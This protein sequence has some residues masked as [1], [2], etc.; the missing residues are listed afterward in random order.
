[1]KEQETKDNIHGKDNNA[2][3]EGAKEEKQRGEEKNA[4][5]NVEPGCK[6]SR[7]REEDRKRERE[8]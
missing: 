4:I 6:N 8:T 2:H 5:N 7:I 1:M 3:E